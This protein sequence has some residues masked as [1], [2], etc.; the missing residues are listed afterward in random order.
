MI[1]GILGPFRAADRSLVPVATP[2]TATAREVGPVAERFASV[3]DYIQSYPD[4]VQDILRKI[5]QT[6]RKAV[7]GTEEKIS[8]GIPSV[9]LDGKHV[10][11]FAAWKHHISVYPVPRL[12]GSMEQDVAPYLAAKGTLRFPFKNPIP[13]DL[14]GR[15]AALL[16]EQRHSNR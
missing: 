14:I 2:P 6:I 8:Y 9:T 16:A 7:P 1:A 4:E 5:R 12:A 3:D 15:V 11:Y 10:V 13:Y